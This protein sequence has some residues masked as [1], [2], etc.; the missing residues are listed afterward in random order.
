MV[1][2]VL[3]VK[4][5][6]ELLI[7]NIKIIEN[8]ALKY[9]FSCI[10]TKAKDQKIIC[11]LVVDEVCIR[12]HIEWDGEKMHGF[13]DMGANINNCDGDNLVH[14]KNALLFMAVGI[15]GHWK[16]PLDYFLIGMVLN[17]VIY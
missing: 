6:S 14:A 15:N 2:L 13:V 16:M 12:D 17:V 5:F 1:N 8:F 9:F 3:L 10:E 7:L 4:H 11:N